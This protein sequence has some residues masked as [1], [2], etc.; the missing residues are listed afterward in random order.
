M[1]AVLTWLKS[2]VASVIFFVVMVAALVALPIVASGLNEDVRKTV[3]DRVSSYNDL[4]KLTKTSISISSATGPPIQE[5]AIVN[6]RL[7]ERYRAIVDAEREDAKQVRERAVEH[8]RKGRNVLLP[9]LFPEPPDAQREVLPERFYNLVTEAYGAL[10]EDVRAGTPP[11]PESMQEYIERERSKFYSQIL[12]KDLADTLS[13]EEQDELRENLANKRMYRYVKH[14]ENVRFYAGLDAFTLP[15]WEQ[16]NQPSPAELF[17]WQWRYWVVEDVLR[18]IAGANSDEAGAWVQKQPVKRVVQ[19]NVFAPDYD[20]PASGGGGGGSGAPGFGGGGGR[21]GGAAAGPAPVAVNPSQEVKPD[22]GASFT[23]RVTNP[24]YDVRHVEA[25]LVVETEQINAVLDAIAERNFITIVD[26]VM[27]PADH[28]AA[29]QEGF[30]FGEQPVT[31]L[32]LILETVW[33]REWTAPFMPAELK[34]ALRIPDPAA[35][36]PSG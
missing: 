17:D 27:T 15:F 35:A 9:S 26:L 36:P 12:Q 20:A 1:S 18:G 32:T 8:N 34:Q 14:A 30:Y 33:L 5:S 10:L 16:A 4:Q 29:A 19:I 21:G 24:L 2:N 23:G 6:Q 22:F 25:R 28:F 11:T 13:P 7:L 3:K 31:E